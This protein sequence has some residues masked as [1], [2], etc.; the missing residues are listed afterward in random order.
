MTNLKLQR[1]QTSKQSGFT[2]IELIVV[3]LLLG[4]L[5]A[6][7]LPRFLD[8]T[9]EAHAAV[10]DGVRSGLVTGSALFRAQWVGEGQRTNTAITQFNGLWPNSGGYP[11]GTLDATLGDD[12]ND[13]E[14]IYISLL[15]AGRPSVDSAASTGS[16]INGAEVTIAAAAGVDILAKYTGSNECTYAYIAQFQSVTGDN[17]PD[18]VLTLV[19]GTFEAGNVREGA[20][21]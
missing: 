21:L 19:D 20:A 18:L 8:V 10:V 11:V 6:T 15:Q 3:I 5:A 17:I 13:C 1:L 4:I 9:D 12:A 14:D 2:I 16:A 7:A